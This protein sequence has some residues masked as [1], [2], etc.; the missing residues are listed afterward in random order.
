M[1]MF[2]QLESRRM[3]SGTTYDVQVAV[4]PPDQNGVEHATLTVFG[5]DNLVL[6]AKPDGSFDVTNDNGATL[7]AFALSNVNFARIPITEIDVLETA[8]GRNTVQINTD[9]TTPPLT[10]NISTGSGSDTLTI[11]GSGSASISFDGGA[12]NDIVI[13][14]DPNAII[15]V[16]S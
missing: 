14:N 13:D 16:V 9:S 7:N 3:L 8:S 1:Q 6:T 2:E 11:N 5:A 12:G 10:A 15:T 4:A